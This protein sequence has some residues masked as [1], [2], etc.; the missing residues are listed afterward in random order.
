MLNGVYY[1]PTKIFFGK[2][3]ETRV[4]QE[5]AKYSKKI[6]LHF[7]KK[8]FKK[9]GLYNKVSASLKSAGITFIEL[10]GVKPNPRVDLVYQGIELCRKENIDF[11][12]AVGGGSVIDS[13]KAIS[14]GVP[15]SGD[16]FDFFEGKSEPKKALKVATILTIPGSGS[17]SGGGAVITHQEKGLKLAYTNSIMTPIFSILNP[18][19][20]YTLNQYYTACGIMDAISHLLERYFTKTTYVD[21]TDRIGEG[22]IKT[23][24]KYALLVK[25]APDNYDIRAEIMWVS[26]LAHDNTAGFGRQQDWS[27]HRIAVELGAIYD[28]THGAAVGVI[29]LAW[30]KYVYKANI[31]KFIQFNT[32]IFD[33]DIKSTNSKQAV[34]KAI[35]KLKQFIKSI[36]LP[37]SLREMKIPDKKC[38]TEISKKCVKSM[39]SG[40]IGNY[41][42]LSPQ[43]IVKILE[44]AYK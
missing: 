19:L 31:D 1:Q 44:I 34:L 42:R 22:L 39:P 40:T 12:L 21:C 3:M 14:I 18:E 26:K 9:Y 17:E 32:R 27:S 36:G 37:T 43:D 11:I 6:L 20:T 2:E 41:V 10:G 30:M 28:V 38:F 7:G 23:L 15:W 33:V 35:D 16:F 13:A 24:M 5:V 4:G 25:E 29:F 8:S